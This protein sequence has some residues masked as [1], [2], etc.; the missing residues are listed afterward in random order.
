MFNGSTAA[1]PKRR[2]LWIL[3]VLALLLILLA[4]GGIGGILM[5][6]GI[7]VLLTALFALI[8]QRRTWMRL[9]HR[10][11]AGIVAGLGVVALFAGG[12]VVGATAA[13]SA[14][15]ANKSALLASPAATPADTPTPTPTATNPVRTACFS[16]AA[17]Q[18]YQ[19]AALVCTKDADGELLWLPEAESKRIVKAAADKEAAEKK[20]AADKAAAEKAA[21]EKKA[22]ER[23]AAQEKAAADKAAANAAAAEAAR[24]SPPAPPVQVAPVAPAAPAAVYFPNCAAAK[25]AGAAPMFAGSPGYRPQL[26]RDKDGIACDK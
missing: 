26:D 17:T 8:T 1:R 6:L 25:A 13:P 10:K 24:L 4:A 7:V 22:A 20:A 16:A 12:G 9:P 11:S 21:A 18:A 19:G 3:A 2:T 23:K 5:I 14:P 15:V